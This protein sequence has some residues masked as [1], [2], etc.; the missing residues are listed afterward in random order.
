[1]GCSITTAAASGSETI[2]PHLPL[3]LKFEIFIVLSYHCYGRTC[4]LPHSSNPL[5]F[6]I[7]CTLVL[8]VSASLIE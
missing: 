4:Q 1:M 5:S 2:G 7:Y 3:C 6:S 8:S